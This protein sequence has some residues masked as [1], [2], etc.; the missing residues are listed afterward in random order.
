MIFKNRTFGK[1]ENATIAIFGNGTISIVDGY[2]KELAYRSIMM[3]TIPKKEIGEVVG[4]EKNSDE[5]IPE[6]VIIFEN[7]ESFDVF[8]DYVL[9]I[10]VGFENEI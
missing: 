2:N 10:K 1:I 7:K 8:Y 5:F 6:L 4:S 9:N 3:K